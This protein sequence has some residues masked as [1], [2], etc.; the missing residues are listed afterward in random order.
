MFL[1]VLIILIVS[2]FISNNSGGNIGTLGALI[3]VPIL[4]VLCPHLLAI[5]IPI[6][7]I[8]FIYNVFSKKL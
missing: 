5:I 7:I 8:W 3:L 6:G 1:I 2:L 4:M